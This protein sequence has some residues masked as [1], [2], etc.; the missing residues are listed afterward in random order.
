MKIQE[1]ALQAVNSMIAQGYSPATAWGEYSVNLKPIIKMHEQ[2]GVDAFDEEILH[3]YAEKATR[4]YN[5]NEISYNHYR[6]MVGAAER[7]SEFEK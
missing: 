3:E 2:K 5:A 6:Y 1:L 4:R 7:F